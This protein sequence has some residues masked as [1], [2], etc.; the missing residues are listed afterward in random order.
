MG[1]KERP[2]AVI[3]PSIRSIKLYADGRIDYQGKSGSVV[4]ATARI[5][6]S[7][8]KHRL[9]DTRKV[10]LRV[11]GPSVA[12]AA[13]LP[14][15]ALQLHRRA[16]EFVAQVNEMSNGVDGSD[17]APVVRDAPEPPPTIDQSKQVDSSGSVAA[18]AHE[19]DLLLMDVLIGQLERLG[20][21]RD[22]GVLTEDEF[23]EQKRVLLRATH[24][25]RASA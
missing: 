20:K 2:V 5:E 24:N 15:S 12:I 9:R 6:R 13:P 18:G 21:L 11:D 23:Q 4:G 7:G 25:S 16:E 19:A 10:V 17:P 22:S 1:G 8:E 14:A 3:A